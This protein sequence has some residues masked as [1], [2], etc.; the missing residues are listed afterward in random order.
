MS[1]FVTDEKFPLYSGKISNLLCAV[2]N[3]FSLQNY[4]LRFFSFAS[5]KSAANY[6]KYVYKM[7][8][9]AIHL[10]HCCT[11]NIE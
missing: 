9:Y 3:H 7:F 5:K 10:H 11:K 2:D 6:F 4:T 1:P 8:F